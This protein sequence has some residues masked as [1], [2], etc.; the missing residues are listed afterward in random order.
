MTYT[1]TQ[2]TDGFPESVIHKSCIATIYQT[3]NRGKYRYEVRYHDA[4]GV[5]QRATFLVYEQA[6]QYAEAIVRELAS[7]GL[8]VLPLR[9]PERRIHERALDLLQPLGL[10]LD[11][12][13]SEVVE[14]RKRLKDVASPVEAVDYYLKIRPKAAPSISVRAVVDEFIESRRKEEVGALY[15]RDL[16]N[17]LGALADAFQCSIRTRRLAWRW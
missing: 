17:R 3:N 14:L 8:D 9:G 11:E 10:T 6:K 12:A 2:P 15:L 4:D 7:G 13:A 16:R 1:I 5:R